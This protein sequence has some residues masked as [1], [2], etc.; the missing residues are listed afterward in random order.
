M[1]KPK[2]Y[3][4]TP[5]WQLL[6]KDL[7]VKPAD[8]LRRA[9]LSEELLCSDKASLTTEEMF[10]F[11]ESTEAE[12]NDPLFPLRLAEAFSVET[13]SPP[14]FATICSENLLAAAK[15][16]SKYKR[17]VGPMALHVTETPEQLA[18]QMEWLDV[19]QNPPLTLVIAELIFLLQM[20]R[21]ATREHIV[22]LCVMTTTPPKEVDAYK[23][24][25]GVTIEQGNTHTIVYS[26][27]DA[28]LPFLTANDTM[29][30]IFEPVLQKRLAKLNA[31]AS[32][33]E[34]VKAVLLEALPS[35]SYSIDDI[36]RKLALGK[37]TLQRRLTVEQ[38]SFRNILDNTREELAR[39]Y[40]T[41]TSIS[42]TEISFL[43]GFE[44]PNS[45]YRAFQTWTGQTPEQHR[46]SSGPQP[47]L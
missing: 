31:S 36:S 11:W 23:Q 47:S 24:F 2:V 46:R 29:W 42:S 25:M 19:S 12:L 17:L 38:T 6:L 32:T 39:F 18:L 7:G 20:A 30:K 45:F 43:L 8:V 27:K 4:V 44:E 41:T 28:K 15:R 13:F 1:T 26:M 10:R 5:G 40:L 16:L 35:G 21:V 33:S 3:P 37:R 14:I 22:P 9:K 34:K